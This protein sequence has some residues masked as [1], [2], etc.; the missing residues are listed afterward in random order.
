LLNKYYTRHG[1]RHIS[2][3]EFSKVNNV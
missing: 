3:M 1:T 2:L